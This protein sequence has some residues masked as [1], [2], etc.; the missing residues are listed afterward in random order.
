MLV[1]LVLNEVINNLLLLNEVRNFVKSVNEL[2]GR[3]FQQ[4][5]K[6]ILL[7]LAFRTQILLLKLHFRRIFSRIN[8][9]SLEFRILLVQLI[10]LVPMLL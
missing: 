5:L 2:I 10:V 7:L 1:V 3:L 9:Y 6:L 8:Y 4:T